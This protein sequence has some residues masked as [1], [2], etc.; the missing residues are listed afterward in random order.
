MCFSPKSNLMVMQISLLQTATRLPKLQSIKCH[1][2]LVE[3]AAMIGGINTNGD[4]LDYPDDR[5]RRFAREVA[6]N[7]E[8]SHDITFSI[9][10]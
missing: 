8:N 6:E 1:P 10:V 5:V 7:F 3:P 9:I 2:T 4:D